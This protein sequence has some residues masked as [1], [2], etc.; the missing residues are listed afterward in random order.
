[1]D[2]VVSEAVTGALGHLVEI[3]TRYVRLKHTVKTSREGASKS[4]T[5]KT[6]RGYLP[7]LEYEKIRGV[8]DCSKT[9]AVGLGLFHGFEGLLLSLSILRTTT[10]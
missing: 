4:S 1:L 7:R 5:R 8:R 9:V 10:R 3:W 6:P 2:S